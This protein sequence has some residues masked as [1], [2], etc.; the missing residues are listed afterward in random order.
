[1]E[2]QKIKKNLEILTSNYMFKL[3]DKQLRFKSPELNKKYETSMIPTARLNVLILSLISIINTFVLLIYVLVVNKSYAY[4]TYLLVIKY[5]VIGLGLIAVIVF[6]FYAK[7]YK[8][9]FILE[10]VLL[11]IVFISNSTNIVYVLAVNQPGKYATKFQFYFNVTISFFSSIFFSFSIYKSLAID[12]ILLA[13]IAIT[14]Y[15]TP[16]SDM[17]IEILYLIITIIYFELYN[18][19]R[20]KSMKISFLEKLQNELVTNYFIDLISQMNIGIGVT[21]RKNMIMTNEKFFEFYKRINPTSDNIQNIN[22]AIENEPLIDSRRNSG[23]LPNKINNNNN[24][25][26]N[27][28]NFDVINTNLETKNQD[29]NNNNINIDPEIGVDAN[30][31]TENFELKQMLSRLKKV[32]GGDAN[33]LNETNTNNIEITENIYLSDRRSGSSKDYNEKNFKKLGLFKIK[34][35]VNSPNS[36]NN[37]NSSNNST[38]EIYLSNHK[39]FDNEMCWILIYDVSDYFEKEKIKEDFK[40][41]SNFIAKISH[42]FTTPIMAIIQMLKSCYNSDENL[43]DPLKNCKYLCKYLF[44]L[45][46]ELTFYLN[47][48][49]ILNNENIQ[50]KNFDFVKFL[51]KATNI[52]FELKNLNEKK[53]Q[54]IIFNISLLNGQNRIN[55]GDLN[56]FKITVKS[57]YNMLQQFLINLFI[58]IYKIVFGGDIS[59][60]VNIGN[61]QIATEDNEVIGSINILIELSTHFNIADFTDNKGNYQKVQGLNISYDLCKK[62]A[63]ELNLNLK[64]EKEN[65]NLLIHF[66]LNLVELSK[67]EISPNSVSTIFNKKLDSKVETDLIQFIKNIYRNSNKTINNINNNLVDTNSFLNK[68]KSVIIENFEEKEKENNGT[69]EIGLLKDENNIKS[70]EI[71]LKES[72]DSAFKKRE[73][74]SSISPSIN[75]S[76]NNSRNS[77][78]SN[79]NFTLQRKNTNRYLTKFERQ[80]SSKLSKYFKANNTKYILIADDVKSIRSSLKNILNS[81]LKSFNSTF[82]IL[83]ST[84]GIELLNQIYGLS[85]SNKVISFIITDQ[86]MN[87]MNGSEAISIINNLVLNKKIS[88]IPI[89]VNTA[90]QDQINI[91]AINDVNP[92][93]V[94]T[95][96]L[97]KSALFDI[98]KEFKIE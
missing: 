12:L 30:L 60:S 15:Y 37:N 26:Q 61:N 36:I 54:N 67:E 74:S 34:E 87:F 58:I 19:N 78:N 82:E 22:R 17:T 97:T 64:L 55:A 90:F 8:A 75:N 94:V 47:N 51:E 38:F 53:S 11:G 92:D 85:N 49:Q 13:I 6:A 65:E 73:E 29:E 21:N 40:V 88:K 39:L 44:I 84:D 57:D 93:K 45:I 2:R 28:N 48:D 14:E 52:I 23:T 3:L 41:K 16:D 77:N 9:L 83:E 24:N 76:N 96:P 66:Q 86:F 98:I 20:D 42:E 91:K 4:P 59:F 5:V 32:K 81:V 50:I 56:S 71:V 10:I 31:A 79:N 62:L 35:N 25:N 1:M 95:K 43:K 69:P 68:H 80:N 72:S 33:K 46:N 27:N 7:S 63:K 89:I 18:Y 70:K